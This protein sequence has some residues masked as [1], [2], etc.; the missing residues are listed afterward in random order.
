MSIVDEV[1]QMMNCLVGIAEE[2]FM[3]VTIFQALKINMPISIEE[4]DPV[5]P[6]CP[7]RYRV[8]LLQAR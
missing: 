6:D 2:M 4:I 3:Q 5:A 1:P 8:S 7:V